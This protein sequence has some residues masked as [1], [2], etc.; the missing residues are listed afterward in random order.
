M[1]IISFYLSLLSTSLSPSCLPRYLP[2]VSLLSPLLSP[3]CLPFCLP[4]VS[5][6]VS[7]LSPSLSPSCLPLI[8]KWMNFLGEMLDC[9]WCNSAFVNPRFETLTANWDRENG[10]YIILY[11]IRCAIPLT[12]GNAWWKKHSTLQYDTA[13][14][15]LSFVRQGFRRRVPRRF[16]EGS[17][18]ESRKHWFNVCVVR[19]VPNTRHILIDRPIDRY[20]PTGIHT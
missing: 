20:N 9:W 14:S 10:L 1:K 8:F 7:L 6:S 4:P 15:L 2:P 17:R 12:H 18:K 13:Y 19:R 3:S 11:G 5:L 16:P